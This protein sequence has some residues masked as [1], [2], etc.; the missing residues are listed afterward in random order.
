[1]GKNTSEIAEH[2]TANE[3]E[4]TRNNV[5]QTGCWIE[6]LTSLPTLGRARVGDSRLDRVAQGPGVE[7]VDWLESLYM[8]LQTASPT[9]HSPCA[10]IRVPDTFVLRYMRPVAWYHMEHGR[11]G[12]KDDTKSLQIDSIVDL[13]KRKAKGSPIIAYNVRDKGVKGGKVSP[14][15]EY[16]DA[17]GLETF[18][19]QKSKEA[20]GIIQSVIPPPA[21]HKEGI[22]FQVAT[23]RVWWTPSFSQVEM[24]INKNNI[25]DEKNPYIDRLVT[26]DGEEHQSTLRQLNKGS[27][28]REAALATSR[29]LTHIS[30]LLPLG[31]G[32]RSMSLYFRVVPNDGLYLLYCAQLRLANLSLKSPLTVVPE[33][34]TQDAVKSKRGSV[35]RPTPSPA[36]RQSRSALG[37]APDSA[38]TK[39]SL[40][41]KA[42]KVVK[43]NEGNAS[44]LKKRAPPGYGLC[45]ICDQLV[46]ED[47]LYSVT[48]SMML[49]HCERYTK[50]VKA[51]TRPAS[52]NSVLSATTRAPTPGEILGDKRCTT[53]AL[54]LSVPAT[55]HN[56]LEG[57]NGQDPQS[58][59]APEE[60]ALDPSIP[61]LFLKVNP[62]LKKCRDFSRV[63]S[64][65]DFL[66]TSVKVCETDCLIFQSSAVSDMELSRTDMTKQPED[67]WED[68][69]K[70][71]KFQNVPRSAAP[72]TFT[73]L[74]I[75]V[76]VE[77]S[78]DYLGIKKRKPSASEK[79]PAAAD[80]GTDDELG[81]KTGSDGEGRLERPSSLATL[82]SELARSLSGLHLPA[83][84]TA[85]VKRKKKK[86]KSFLHDNRAATA[87]LP[88]A[89]SALSQYSDDSWPF[90]LDDH[91]DPHARSASA[92]PSF[93]ARGGSGDGELSPNAGPKTLSFDQSCTMCSLDHILDG[94]LPNAPQS[95]I[96]KRY[97]CG[98]RICGACLRQVVTLRGY[99]GVKNGCPQCADLSVQSALNPS[100][101][102]LVSSDTLRARAMAHQKAQ[103]SPVSMQFHV[104]HRRERR[105]RKLQ[106]EASLAP[107]ESTSLSTVGGEGNRIIGA[108]RFRL[109][110]DQ[111][112]K[113]D[114]ALLEE[115]MSL[116]R[117]IENL[118]R[119][120]DH[121]RQSPS[122]QPQDHR[123]YPS[124]FNRGSPGTA[125]VA[126]SG[127]LD[128]EGDSSQGR[129]FETPMTAPNYNPTRT[130]VP[131]RESVTSERPTSSGSQCVDAPLPYPEDTPTMQPS[132]AS[133]ARTEQISSVDDDG[134]VVTLSTEAA[135]RVRGMTSREKFR[136][137]SQLKD[138][139]SAFASCLEDAG[140][141]EDPSAALAQFREA[142]GVDT[143][144]ELLAGPVPKKAVQEFVGTRAGAAEALRTILMAQ[145]RQTACQLTQEEEEWAAMGL[146]AVV[147][148]GDDDVAIT[149]AAGGLC[150]LTLLQGGRS[151][152]N[153]FRRPSMTA[154]NTTSLQDE[155]DRGTTIVSSTPRSSIGA[156][157]MF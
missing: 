108:P 22:P 47:Q 97:K 136:T 52:R 144:V 59:S 45:P 139:A 86:R 127:F 146:Q 80:P 103:G 90:E 35:L 83:P 141:S 49:K 36:K 106:H 8:Y 78:Q 109:G 68:R 44:R 37:A 73:R 25:F 74:P 84:G 98:H 130:S 43:P 46:A 142:G 123:A 10:G 100:P 29:I 125:P 11:V 132:R 114:E 149:Q 3:Q 79:D 82:D 14:E 117:Q 7:Q 40:W 1:M 156:D 63:K 134:E 91:P 105:A 5:L 51:R 55:I 61:L 152:R 122:S 20:N 33:K 147:S 137:A 39:G 16:F 69:P 126:G 6:A 148:R 85:P 50:I 143:L 121:L 111:K 30:E 54:S 56:S 96:A 66:N 70:V 154:F 53:P 42:G 120:N 128:S 138:L 75:Y 116:R 32:I 157:S 140:G 150:A 81:A 12:K 48:Y 107:V 89:S 15:I 88:R 65:A 113:A 38:S 110:V 19:S 99:V 87:D 27:L 23:L 94:A 129:S 145:T 135:Q 119:E 93:P 155:Q 77:A 115:N 64:T 92:E 76:K 9:T 26:F 13:F 57:E 151:F 2:R 104:D 31:Y 102:T 112:F 133:S 58:S 41:P 62:Q 28:S 124:S 131:T 72:P 21:S 153:T 101:V 60:P 18:L 71:T 34:R 95:P 17:Q 67:G 118:R 24:R 4:R